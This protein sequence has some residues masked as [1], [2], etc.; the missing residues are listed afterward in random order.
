MLVQICLAIEL[1]HLLLLQLWGSLI[2]SVVTAAHQRLAKVQSPTT[3]KIFLSKNKKRNGTEQ[4]VEARNRIKKTPK[5]IG[6]CCPLLSLVHTSHSDFAASLNEP[7]SNEPPFGPSVLE[8]GLDLR[9]RH[10]QVLGQRR[11]LRRRKILL[12][13]KTLLKLANLN[14]KK[15]NDFFYTKMLERIDS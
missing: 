9:V 1:I 6:V 11:P 7:L 13:V 10:L 2:G 12:L 15:F 8:P 4:T 5:G 3:E 14:N